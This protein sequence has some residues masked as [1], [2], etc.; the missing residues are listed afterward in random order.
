MSLNYQQLQQQVRQWGEQAPQRQRELEDQRQK[1]RQALRTHAAEPERLRQKALQAAREV[2]YLR[3]ALPVEHDPPGLDAAFPAPPAPAQATLIAA[4]GSQINPDRHAEALYCLINVG[5]I[6]MELGSAQAPR[7]SVTT[8]LHYDEKLYPGGSLMTDNTVALLRDLGERTALAGLA[9]AAAL[10]PVITFTDGPLELWGSRAQEDA[11]DFQQNLEKYLDSLQR[12]HDLDA[13]TAGYVDRPSAD[14]LVRLLEI[15]LTPE[16]SL[17]R[18]ATQRL[19][20]PYITDLDLMLDLLA[21]G[22]R[23]AVFALQSS[24]VEKYTGSLALHFF[25]LNVGSE[26]QPWLARVEVPGWVAEDSLK[27]GALHAV[28]LA[29]CQVLGG[30]A[31]PYLLH[32]AHETAVVRYEEKEQVTQLILHELRARGVP[33]GQKS[34][35]QAVKDLR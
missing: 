7:Q 33:V 30:R 6:Q 32:R 2:R 35:K 19:F 4:D 14:L 13:I 34:H 31:Y 11:S 8:D 21:P 20:P 18:L 27:L 10:K 5:A 25:Y 23:S 24:A 28:L 1:A 12:L 15:A 9:Q 29:Q 16:E 26:N 3:C 17:G 22:E